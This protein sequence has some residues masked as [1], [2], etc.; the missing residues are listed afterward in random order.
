MRL[1]NNQARYLM[2]LPF[3]ALNWPPA[4]PITRGRPLPTDTPPRTPTTTSWGAPPAL[5]AP[6]GLSA[7]EQKRRAW[8]ENPIRLGLYRYLERILSGYGQ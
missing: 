6:N 1:T 5:N 7:K 8:L 3:T 4:P 2:L